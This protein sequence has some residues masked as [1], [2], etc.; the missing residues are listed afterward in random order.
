MTPET[1]S[2]VHASEVPSTRG[3]TAGDT[4]VQTSTAT[5]FRGGGAV[6]GRSLAL[7]ALVLGAVA[8]GTLPAAADQ[9]TSF[10]GDSFPLVA[11]Q[12]QVVTG[13]TTVE[14]GTEVTARIQS[15]EPEA[16]FL[17]QSHAE[18]QDDGTFVAVLDLS[19][20]P[21]NTSYE[22]AVHS[23]GTELTNRSGTI[24]ACENDCTD[25]IPETPTPSETASDPTVVTV[26]QGS[27]AEI[28]VPTDAGETRTLSVGG[29]GV[30]Y[31]INATVTDG[32]GDGEVLVL[33]D[34]ANAGTDNATLTAADDGDSVT[35]T[36]PEPALSSPLDPA[37]YEFRLFDE[38]DT[39][40]RP[41]TTGTLQIEDDGTTDGEYV[42]EQTGEFGFE[43]AVVRTGQSATAELPIVLADAD[44][45]SLSIGSPDSG[46][47]I[48]AT[49]R[50]GNGDGRVVVRFDATAAGRDGATLSTAADAD[51]V[52]VQPGSEVALDSRL[53]AAN[54]D[55]TLYRGSEIDGNPDEI[56]TL[57]VTAR[58]DT[59]S[60]SNEST[61]ASVTGGDE[62]VEQR[63]ALGAGAGVLTLG[64]VLGIAGIAVIL[65]A[66]RG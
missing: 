14:P 15:T 32:D 51:A 13:E 10:D 31:M 57:V 42:V 26:E 55:L 9:Q 44:A 29:P 41:A 47:E 48:N 56:G 30:N 20:V 24:R 35:I 23:D 58:N 7:A 45:A 27:T 63:S 25:P 34:T 62:Q 36:H 66:I 54:Y 18:V 17:Y 2:R 22:L 65:R 50:D 61:D 1:N 40:G 12:Q 3:V 60:L 19:A 39:S 53:D 52:S 28:P 38:T 16:P 33:F 21:A 49:V 59:A 64:G 43:R 5:A 8:V 6:S 4:A 46:Y 37:A 11:A